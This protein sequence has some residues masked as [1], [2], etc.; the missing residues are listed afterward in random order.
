MKRLLTFYGQ[1]LTKK[2]VDFITSSN[3]DVNVKTHI[4]FSKGLGGVIEGLDVSVLNNNTSISVSPGSFYNSG[5]YSDTN[6]AGGGERATV[7]KTTVM[8]NFEQTTDIG[9]QK[10]YLLVYAKIENSNSD[11]DTTKSNT[12]LTSK[13]IQTGENIPIRQYPEG[14]IKVSYKIT[15]S[16]INKIAGIPLALLSVDSNGIITPDFSVKRNYLIGGIFDILNSNIVDAAIPNNFITSR[17]LGNN[18]VLNNNISSGTIATNSLGDWDGL[19]LYNDNINGSGIS[20]QQLKNGAITENKLNYQL[21]LNNFGNRNRLLNSS[22]ETFDSNKIPVSWSGTKGT[23][24]NIYDNTRNSGGTDNV[25]NGVKYGDWSVALA[26]YSVV[27]TPNYA[28]SGNVSQIIDFGM[29]LNNVPITAFFWAKEVATSNSSL[30]GFTGL[31]GKVEFLDGSNN[32]V[33]NGIFEFSGTSYTQ[34][35]FTQ[36][37]YPSGIT[38]TG[39]T[40]VRSIKYSIGGSFDG[41]YYIDGA[42]LGA[43]SIIPEY[44]LNPSEYISINNALNDGEI[45]TAHIRN[46]DNSISTDVGNGIITTQIRDNSITTPKIAD[47]AI[48]AQK[49]DP[50]CGLIP[51]G[52]III[53]DS[54]TSCPTGFTEAI[55][56]AGFLPLGRNSSSTEVSISIPG[57]NNNTA[58]ISSTTSTSLN[59]SHDHTISNSGKGAAASSDYV[60]AAQN[61]S[62]ASSHA[63]TIPFR[64]VLFCRKTS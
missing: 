6:N 9:N 34:N 2:D 61:T 63:H 62:T 57:Y 40:N 55:E 58:I 33:S 35:G 44:D 5:G 41:K 29:N 12:I 38:Y 28:S 47:Y 64:T 59:G 4:D 32:I 26:G 10:S 49:L 13:N 1:V 21:S 14:V 25:Q 15:K 56:Y 11:P 42:Y 3:R 31:K 50:G 30:S 60:A 17:M 46:V 23:G 18:Q 48:T 27:G 51:I 8:T 45:Q 53:W 54:G 20:N 52:A 16:D 36:Y 22:F 43:S 39:G 7:Y 24:F 19:T 37:S